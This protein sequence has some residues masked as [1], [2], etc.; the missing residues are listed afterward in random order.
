M[1][2]R[3]V[4]FIIVAALAVGLYRLNATVRAFVSDVTFQIKRELFTFIDNIQKR[5]YTFLDQA[6]KIETLSKRNRELERYRILYADLY[7]RLKA[8]QKECNLTIPSVDMRL[9]GAIAYMKFGDYSAMWLDAKLE[10]QKIY[11]LIKDRSVAGIA[12]QKDGKAVALFNGNK[13]CS[14]GVITQSGA[15]GVA[16]G[17]G[18]NRYIIVKYIPTYEHV[19]IGQKVLTSGLDAIFPYGIPVGEVVRVWQEGSYKVAKVKTYADLSHPRFLWL[20][21]L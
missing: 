12:V 6:Y 3:L 18:D 11:G 13:K 17:S 16:M 1:S 21:K 5:Y 20:M 9:V 7:D 19:Q 8:L 2:K 10:P 15:Q 14:Y 4:A